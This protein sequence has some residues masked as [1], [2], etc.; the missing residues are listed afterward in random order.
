MSGSLDEPAPSRIRLELPFAAA[1]AL[2]FLLAVSLGLFA[3]SMILNI[4]DVL[5]WENPSQLVQRY[6][7]ADSERSVTTWFSACILML[8]ALMTL[9]ARVRTGST[10]A[11]AWMSALFVA[12]S[13]DEI[14]VIHEEIGAR[15]NDALDTGGLLRFGFVIPGAV[16]L[17][18]VILLF[19]PL[20]SSLP[21]PTR[22]VFLWGAALYVGGALALDAVGELAHDTLGREPLI[23][24]TLAN[25]EELLEMAGASV[26]VYAFAT[27]GVVSLPE[28]P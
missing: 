25:I 21:T 22:T 7:S 9:A 3:V 5:G 11:W 2:I 16:I 27:Y 18:G 19:A 23:S 13:A 4:A 26:L 17:V 10:A 20:I 1:P 14:L 28:P 15:I 24:V 12:M 6:L 8:C